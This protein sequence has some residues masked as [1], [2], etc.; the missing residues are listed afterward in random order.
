MEKEQLISKNKSLEETVQR[1]KEEDD[2]RNSRA[3]AII[4][5]YF[6]PSV[7]LSNIK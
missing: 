1:C 6:K 3:Q 2:M 5:E 4:K 7:A